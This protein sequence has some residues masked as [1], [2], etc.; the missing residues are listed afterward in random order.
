M[1]NS[2]IVLVS[3]Q[4]AF[5]ICYA[6]AP[7]FYDALYKYWLQRKRIYKRICAY[8]VSKK[9]KQKKVENKEEEEK[10]ARV[11]ELESKNPKF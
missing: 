1:G 4:T 9:K 8:L 10:K 5:F 7:G 2:I 3:G 6:L 11:L